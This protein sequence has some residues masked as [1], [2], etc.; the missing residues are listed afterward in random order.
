[1]WAKDQSVLLELRWPHTS[2]VE[3]AILNHVVV[4]EGIQLLKLRAPPELLTVDLLQDFECRVMD[5]ENVFEV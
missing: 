3:K 4:H 2:Q 5:L 1:M